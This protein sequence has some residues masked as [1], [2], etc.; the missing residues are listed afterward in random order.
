MSRKRYKKSYKTRKRKS[1]LRSRVFW[2]VFLVLLI[3]GN[4][5]Y[6][7]FFSKVF[8]VKEIRIDG[9]QKIAAAEIGKIISERAK[10]ASNIFLINSKELGSFILEKYPLIGSINF[11]RKLPD[12]LSVQI[13]ERKPVAVLCNSENSECFYIDN[14]AV[15]FEK[16][17]EMPLEML[18]IR[19]E[20]VNREQ[21]EQLLEINSEITIPIQEISIASERKFIAKTKESWEIYFNPEENLDWQLE[22]FGIILKEKIPP[23]QRGNLE[24]ID[25]RFD[26]VYIYPVK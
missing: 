3:S 4:F 13:E 1:L 16:V 22:E 11:K 25:L 24:Y 8:S 21:L 6:L 10:W 9:A 14:Q 23:E 12:I 18:I 26:K 15:A 7:F 5:V 17:S 19:G 20:E 2:S